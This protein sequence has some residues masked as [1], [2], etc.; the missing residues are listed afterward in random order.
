M[1]WGND[2]LVVGLT[3]GIGCGKSTTLR[4]FEARDWETISVDAIAA[5]LLANDRKVV[6][7]VEK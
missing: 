2:K 4:F 5:D 6:D 3:G 7:A 1:P